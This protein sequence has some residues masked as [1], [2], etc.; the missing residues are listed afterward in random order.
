MKRHFTHTYYLTFCSIIIFILSF[1]QPVKGQVSV[2]T[3]NFEHGSNMPTGWT[4]EYVY[5]TLNWVFTSGGQSSH[6]SAAH[7]G[8]YNALLYYGGIYRTTKLVSKPLNLSAYANLQLKFWHTQEEYSGDQDILKVYYKTSASGSWVQ[9]TSYTTSV[10]SWTQRTISLPNPSANYYIA[11]EGEARYGY[12]VCLD[13]I[14]ITGTVTNGLDMS[15]EGIS[16]PIIWG[17]GNNTLKL[18]Y[19][20]KRSDTIFNA[21]FGYILD[22]NSPVI[23]TNK[24][25]STMLSNQ[26]KEY[27]F[28]NALSISKGNHYIKVWANKPNRTNPDDVPANDTFTLNFGTGIKDTFYIDKNG[29]GDYTTFAAAVADLNNGVTGPVWFF[30]S[31]GTYTEKVI[32]GEIPGASSTNTITFDGLYK[33]STFLSYTGTAANNRATLSLKGADYVTFKNMTIKNEGSTYGVAVLLRNKSDYNTFYNCNLKLKTT[34]TNAYT[35][36]ILASSDES[37]TGANGDNCNYTLF[38]NCLIEGG[39]YGA[40]MHGTNTAAMALNNSFVGCNFS[41]QY[42]YGL[43]LYY[44]RGFNISYSQVANF[45]HSSAYGL[46]NYYGAGISIDANV[47]QPGIHAI[48]LYRENYYNQTDSSYVTNNMIS[49]FGNSVNQRGIYTYSYCYNLNILH[50]SILVNGSSTSPTYAAIYMYYY[51]NNSNIKNNLLAS[52][53]NSYLLSML[54]AGTVSVDYNDYYYDTNS[55]TKFYINYAYATFNTFKSI[56]SYINFPHDLNSFDNVDPGFLSNTNLHL[57][58][59]NSISLMAPPLGVANDIDNEN[60]DL[61][62]G[63][64]I[65]ADEIPHPNRD[66]DIVSIDTPSVLLSGNNPVA[67]TLRNMGVDSLIPQTIYLHYTVNGANQV[68]DSLILTSKLPPFATVKFSFQ[69][70]INVTGAGSFDLCVKISPGIYN[71]PDTLDQICVTKCLGIKDTFYIDASGNGDFMTINAAVNSLQNCGVS[72]NVTFIIKAGTFVERVVIPEVPGASSTRTV[73]FQGVHKDSVLLIHA[74]TYAQKSALL[75][76]GADHIIIKNMKIQNNGNSYGACVHF[77]NAADSNTVENCILTTTV[78]ASSYIIPVLASNSEI[79]YYTYGNTGNGNLIKNNKI[80]GGYFGVSMVGTDK[81]TLCA[82]NKIVGNTFRDQYYMGIYS[83]YQENTEIIGNSIKELG[84]YYGYG[85]YRYYCTKARIESNVIQPGRIGMYLYRENDVYPNN[86]TFIINNMI[87]NFNDGTY[88]AGIY[89]Y[90]YSNKLRIYHNSIYLDG[91]VSYVAYAGISL[92]NNCDSAIVKNNI[93]ASDGNNYLMTSYASHGTIIDYN[94]YYYPNNTSYKFYNSGSFSTLAAYKASNYYLVYPHNVNSFDSIDPGFISYTNLHLTANSAGIGGDTIGVLYDIDGDNR[95]LA[96][97]SLGADE[98]GPV[99][100]FAINNSTQCLDA[101]N[102]ILTNKSQGGSASLSYYW[103]FGDGD[104]STLRNPSHSYSAAGNYTI[105]LIVY[106]SLGCNDTTSKTVYINP[107]PQIGFT[108]NDSMQCEYG[109]YFSFTNTTTVSSGTVSYLW[110]FDDGYSAGLTSPVHAFG[111]ADTFD[112]MLIA[113][114][115]LAC[116]DTMVKTAYVFPMPD[117]DFTINT[118]SQCKLN[119]SFVFTNASSISSGSMTYLWDFG[120]GNSSTQINPTYSYTANGSYDVKLKATSAFYCEDSITKNTTIVP[121]PIASFTTNDTNQCLNGNLFQFTNT[122]SVSAGSLTYYWT[123]GDGSTSTQANPSYSYASG[124]T[125][126]V[127]LLVTTSSSCVDSAMQYVVIHPALIADFSINN[128]TQCL[129]ANSF[130]FTNTSTASSGSMSYYWDFGD[131]SYSTAY[132]PSHSYQ[133]FGSIDVKLI[134][135]STNSCSDTLTKGIS[136]FAMPLNIKDTA[137][138]N[139]LAD[140]LMACY[141][142]TGNA[143]DQSGMLNNGTVFGASLSGD[144]CNKSDSA[145]YFDGND[146]IRVPHALFLT[147]QNSYAASAWIYP[148]QSGGTQYILYKYQSNLYKGYSLALINNKIA[149]DFGGSYNPVYSNQNVNLNEWNHV[150][151]SYNGWNYEIYLNNELVGSGIAANNFQSITPLFIGSRGTANYFKGNID[152]VRIYNKSLDNVEIN[153]LYNEFPYVELKDSFVCTGNTTSIAIHNSGRGIAYQLKDYTS[154]SPIG[155][156]VYGTGCRII[157]PIGTISGQQKLQIVASDSNTACQLVFDTII[158]VNIAPM[159]NANYSVAPSSSCLTANNFFFT[160]SSSVSSGSMQYLW[161]FGDFIT[162]TQA[163]PNHQYNVDDTFSIKLTATT[164]YGCSDSLEK[165]VIVFPQPAADFSIADSSQCFDNNAFGFV[166][167]SSISSGSLSYYWD[168]GDGSSSTVQSPVHSYAYADTFLVKLVVTSANGCQDSIIRTTYLQVNPNPSAAFSINDSTQCLNENLMVLANSSSITSGTISY[169]WRF[170]DGGISSVTNPSYQYSSYDTFDITLLVT[171]DKGCKDSIIH[172]AYIYANP[173]SSFSVND[174]VQCLTGNFY[175]FTNLTTLPYGNANSFWSYGDGSTATAQNPTHSYSSANTYNVKLL[176]TSNYGCIDSVETNVVVEASPIANFTIN[177]SA[178]CL[179]ANS[180]SFTDLSTGGSGTINYFWS[181]GDGSTSSSQNPTHTYAVADTYQVKLLITYGAYCTDS[182]IKQVVV[183]PMPFADFS[184]NDSTQCLTN[185]AISF[186]NSSSINSGSLSYLWTFGDGNSSTSTNPQHSYTSNGNYQV[187]LLALSTEGCRDSVSFAIEIWPMPVASFA[188]NTSSQCLYGNSFVLTNTSSI[189]AGSLSYN[190]TFGDGNSSTSV[191]PSHS[192]TNP[193]TYTIKL[194]VSS[195]NGCLDSVSHTVSVNPM[196]VVDYTISQDTQCFNGNL[197][198]FTNSSTVS[199]GSISYN[200]S[201]GDGANS[202]IENPSYS[203]TNPGNYDVKLVVSTNNSCVDS[204]TKTV[205]IHPNPVVGFSVNDSDQCLNINTFVLTNNSTLS[206][207]TSSYL[208]DFD[209][210]SSSTATSPSK[211]YAAASVYVIKLIANSNANC[212]DS[213]SQ[214]V[215]VYPNPITDFSVNSD[216]QCFANNQFVFNNTSSISSG[217]LNFSWTFGDNQSDT[218]QSPSHSYATS[219]VF[220]V[221]LISTSAYACVDT[222]SQ[223]MLVYPSP[224]AS[225]TVNDSSQCF[226][227]NSFSFNN[228]STINAGT[229]TYLWTFGDGDTSTASS[230]VHTYQTSG[231]YDVKLMV[232]SNNSCLDSA[233]ISLDVYPNPVASIS[234]SDSTQCLA[235]NSFVFTNSSSLLSGNM[236]YLWDFGDGDTSSLKDPIHTYVSDSS[237]VVE[238]VVS[239]NYSC[240]DTAYLNTYVYPMPVASFTVNDS[241]QCLAVNN[242]VLTNNSSIS[243]GNNSY[244][245]DFDDNSTT[246][247]KDT[248]HI[249][250]AAGNYM[251]KLVVSSNFACYDSTSQSVFVYPDPVISFSINDTAQCF[252]GHQF[253]VTDSSN[254]SSGNISYNW[255]LGDGN[256]S[257]LKNPQFSYTTADTFELKLVV[258]SDKACSDSLSQFLYVFPTPDAQFSIDDSVQCFTGNQFTMTNQSQIA[259]GSMNYLWRFGDGDTSSS[260]NTVHTYQNEGSYTVK[261]ILESNLNCQDSIDKNINVLNSPIASF[262]VNDSIQCF[263]QNDFILTN[264][265][266]ISAGLLSYLWDFGDTDTSSSIHVNHNYASADTFQIKLVVHSNDGCFD[267]LEKTAY[268][269]PSPLADFDINDSI[270]CFDG[271]QFIFN[272]QSQISTGSLS[273]LWTFGDGDSSYSAS[274]THYYSTTGSYQVGLLVTSGLAC[275]D[276]FVQSILIHESPLAAFTVNDTDQCDLGNGFIFTNN[277]SVVAGSLGYYWSF[278]DGDTSTYIHPN[279]QYTSVDSFEVKLIVQTTEGCEDSA[280]HIVYV[281][282]TPTV[283]FSINNA[284]QCYGSNEFIFNNLTTVVAPIDWLWDFGDGDTS[285]A[286]FA[287]HTYGLVDTFDVSLIAVTNHFCSDTLQKQVVTL[288]GPKSIFSINDTIQCLVGNSFNFINNSLSGGFV[289]HYYWQMGDGDTSTMTNVW[290]QYQDTG[291]FAV[292]LVVAPDS[293]CT[294]TSQIMIHVQPSP[295]ISFSI[296]DSDQCLSGNQYL[297]T[298]NINSN[299][300]SF[301]PIWDFGDGNIDSSLNPIHTYANA[302][303]YSV[304][305]VVITAE[306]CSDSMYQ[307]IE[308][309]EDPIANFTISDSTQC[310]SGNTFDLTDLSS[311]S[312]TLTYLWIFGDGNSSTKVGNVSHAYNVES[313]YE[314]KLFVETQDGCQDSM[315]KMISVHPQPKAAFSINDTDQCLTGNQF[316]TSNTSSI[317]TG[318]LNYQWSFG[319][320][321]T[322]IQDNPAYSYS[323]FGNYSIKLVAI[324]NKG[325]QDSVIATVDVFENPMANYKINENNQCLL[326]NHYV[327]LNQSSIGSGSLSYL[328][329]FGGGDT[330]SYISTSH[331]FLSAGSFDVLLT[332]TSDKGCKDSITKKSVVHPMPVA[333]FD[334]DKNPQCLVGNLFEFTSS[335]TISSGSMTYLWYFGDGD[336]SLSGISTTHSYDSIMSYPVTLVASS[337]QQCRD[338]IIDQVTIK[339]SPSVY[340]GKDVFTTLNVSFN[341]D[342]GPNYTSYVWHD[343]PGSRIYTVN[344]NSLGLGDHLLYVTITDSFGCDNSDSVW[345]FVWP[346]SIEEETQISY[347]LYPNPARAFFTIEFDQLYDTKV[348]I[349][350]EDMQGRVVYKNEFNPMLTQSKL[351]IDLHEAKGVYFVKMVV[352]NRVEVH[353]VMMY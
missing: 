110:D 182:L 73:T 185:N 328:W 201:F 107:S 294:D 219:G 223:S 222:L 321:A 81:T 114:T 138:S 247:T 299:G 256:S 147:P 272:N 155:S 101:N 106:P 277:S 173:N 279:H 39:Q 195:G 258:N 176:S 150:V 214:T 115:N 7:G 51:C 118:G 340:L 172:Q 6:P 46:I 37:S 296:N 231:A 186:T 165:S 341:L 274:D 288:P 21:D 98:A 180:F 140:S 97:P 68:S 335:S 327:Y 178:Q 255:T 190:W 331:I 263:T 57:D 25:T 16:S 72:D 325:C 245:W 95:C 188:I 75:F 265:S 175:S 129:T 32:I 287:L 218:I 246:T 167:L 271:H 273:Y 350:V 168:F 89:A 59:L 194:I 164:I 133:I 88:Q 329:D 40:R 14:E 336:S 22:N 342:A 65:G 55:N 103:T 203:Y 104:T 289:P 84:L 253:I 60:R 297:F 35:Q 235:N 4:Q 276:T 326:Y 313:A 20:N 177:D 43:Y 76:N 2:F 112:V 227:G 248:N 70:P 77:M 157:L 210:G 44:Q 169:N 137:L 224:I 33:D 206:S 99:S 63:V 229:I 119:N 139:R 281:Y 275:V 53:N 283:D 142:F 260:V 239:S 13:D 192:F 163:S 56:A 170:G 30:V 179:T 64:N 50:N 286:Q 92:Y 58:T 18:R 49:N 292:Q 45:R 305:L 334:I 264:T 345:V 211:Q 78:S 87:S 27:T 47:I 121:T 220:E 337:D 282:P 243:S 300:Y 105:T 314:I 304:K 144:R 295:Q 197:F 136:V 226:N 311:G 266:S 262:V 290:H 204:V 117:A 74:G 23:D 238:F 131:A 208:W 241:S 338:T 268:V 122:S 343:G 149:A 280:M 48:Y 232:F 61:S 100:N 306:G 317:I 205:W 1:C 261:L 310:L 184:V 347:N 339:P 86:E 198:A 207:G 193:G 269:L 83:I 221:E 285:H 158:I 284:V 215:T 127:K 181:F 240:A 124:G 332:A 62:F 151:V 9:L 307:S 196:P 145:Y 330:S 316:L 187:Q 38:E 309:F 52:L 324:S 91:S 79:Y 249:Y 352:G 120:D 217:S 174:T 202:T 80:T 242:F 67:I 308:V 333:D 346:V 252:N 5:D 85:I 82:N 42:Y 322:S 8:S 259:S 41:N 250:S 113:S 148:T 93:I 69:T 152:E 15:C 109:N 24:S 302:G 257:S 319:D 111:Y 233:S 34:A 244:L 159:P 353:K 123:F 251:L 26:E 29:N 130:V 66:L 189:G 146:Y 212:T 171:S 225:F 312:G 199:S 161:D 298:S 156:I 31:S 291:Y 191:S 10:A 90:Y 318:Q 12:G 278:G 237:Y 351:R 183:Y 236:A 162:S 94:D 143:N 135:S 315:M 141:P 28:S 3:E 200:W 344:T 216:S 126:L 71:D 267:S 116:A 293:G 128:S 348:D 160:N 102:F 125:Y 11:F 108:I 349:I 19:K 209:D 228:T 303:I 301:T 166:N 154:G 254:I 320:G 270:Q 17:V 153:A 230:P 213:M 134:A 234:V 54:Y 96:N 323:A 132:S 36:V